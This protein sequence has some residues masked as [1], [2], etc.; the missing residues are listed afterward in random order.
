MMMRSMVCSSVLLAMAG[1][2]LTG[3]PF[4][5]PAVLTINNVSESANI[6]EI[7]FQ[8]PGTAGFGENVLDQQVAPGG[9]VTF[10][11]DGVPT[12]DED[13]NG[14]TWRVKLT[15]ELF[16]ILEPEDEGVFS[17][18]HAGDFATWNWSPGVDANVC[19]D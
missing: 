8:M 12:M 4:P 5:P 15:Y 18:L 6:L 2:S 1:I 7:R 11:L 10:E 19:V 16:D 9:T 17:C 13:E 14:D 3:C